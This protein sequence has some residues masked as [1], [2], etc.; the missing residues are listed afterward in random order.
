MSRATPL[1][2]PS[3]GYGA[4]VRYWPAVWGRRP[5]GLHPFL[6]W[7]L[8]PS[9]SAAPEMTAASVELT[10]R[11]MDEGLERTDVHVDEPLGCLQPFLQQL[12]LL[13]HSVLV[14]ICDIA[15]L[16]GLHL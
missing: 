12:G 7:I 2:A 15:V 13:S 16:H 6:L 10:L 1:D 9:R 11:S 3:S 5:V 14:C 4:E 8:A